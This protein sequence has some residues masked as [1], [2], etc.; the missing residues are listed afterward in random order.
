M[1]MRAAVY[2]GGSELSQETL[3][4]PQFGPDE[5]LLR[6]G[7]AGICGTDLRILRDGH[8][9]IPAG[10]ARVLGHELAG[11]IVARGE[12][13]VGLEVGDRVGV[14]PNIGCG[15][16]AQCIAGWTNLCP[17]YSALGISL[18]GGF[19]E[20][21]RI[22]GE[23]IRQGNVMQIPDHV[24]FAEAALAEPLSCCV[25]GQEAVRLGLGDVVLIIG[26][27]PIGGMHVLLA[28]AQGARSVIVSEL[29][30]SRRRQAIELGADAAVDPEAQSL[31]SVIG[32]ASDGAGADV[33][34]VAAPAPKAQE[35]SL[36]LAAR[37]GRINF[38]GGLP[39]G[40]P[41]I[42]FNS[43]LVHY[44][45]LLVTG[46]TGSNVSHYRTA[47]NAIASGQIDLSP[48][49]GATMPLEGIRE[50]IERARQGAEMRILIEPQ[51]AGDQK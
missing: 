13:V 23:A 14:A 40:K 35:E 51:G 11:E 21:M 26:A 17:D 48:L 31:A 18:D 41:T 43:N 8:H 20:F 10:T 32:E 38:F 50:G 28:K 37:Q 27:G 3:G 9:R 47:M 36:E 46:T 7:A 29:Y 12:Q 5:A 30:E 49:I 16:C 2:Q 42:Q 22:P 15:T 24:S 4:V 25:N 44:K 45:Q 6:V 19:A 33:I 1:G 34:I 39:K